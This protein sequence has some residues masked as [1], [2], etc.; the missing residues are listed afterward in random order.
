MKPGLLLGDE[1]LRRAAGG[2]AMA[3][4][5]TPTKTPRQRDPLGW[6]P[7]GGWVCSAPAC[8]GLKT[9]LIKTFRC[10]GDVRADSNAAL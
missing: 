2:S 4:R 6:D 1:C 8:G 3:L 10:L 5:R 7:N 9:R